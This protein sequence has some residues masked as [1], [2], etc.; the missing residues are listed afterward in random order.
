MVTF[1]ARELRIE[2]AKKG[3]SIAKS[4]FTPEI[5]FFWRRKQ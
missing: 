2:S 4:Q 1:K 5:S 3:V